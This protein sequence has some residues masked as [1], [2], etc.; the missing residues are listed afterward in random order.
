MADEP[1]DLNDVSLAC[2]ISGTPDYQRWLLL[3]ALLGSE[4]AGEN[5]N[6]TNTCLPVGGCASPAYPVQVAFSTSGAPTQTI[7]RSVVTGSGSVAAGKTSITLLSSSDFVGTVAGAAFSASIA[8]NYTAQPGS[9][10]AALAY[11]IS[12]GSLTI[13]TIA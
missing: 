10:L 12:A 7:A 13:S 6:V 8:E 9:T 1:T 3:Q 2:F 11:T 4:G 5:V